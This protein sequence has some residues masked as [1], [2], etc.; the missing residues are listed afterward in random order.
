MLPRCSI[1][2]LVNPRPENQQQRMGRL[3]PKDELE[4]L[5]IF[6]EKS[7]KAECHQNVFRKRLQQLGTHLE[8]TEA[9][10]QT[11]HGTVIFD[12]TLPTGPR[13]GSPESQ[14][15]SLRHKNTGRTRL[16]ARPFGYLSFVTFKMNK[17]SSR[18]EL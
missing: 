3:A 10:Y 16:T 17:T 14:Q 6:E 8:G 11:K 2:R 18:R 9:K 7:P 15:E 13:S 12:P 5:V 1:R 4:R